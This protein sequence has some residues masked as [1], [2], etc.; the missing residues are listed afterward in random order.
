VIR[1]IC[2]F[3]QMYHLESK[4]RQRQARTLADELKPI[5]CTVRR[6]S[7]L[8]YRGRLPENRHAVRR[9]S[10][11]DMCVLGDRSGA[12]SVARSLDS[13]LFCVENPGQVANKFVN[14]RFST[15]SRRG[16]MRM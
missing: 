6:F 4:C 14:A 1:T 11:D 15:R 7:G 2:R 16:I 8:A 3:F 12:I 10:T 9:P 5:P 13:V